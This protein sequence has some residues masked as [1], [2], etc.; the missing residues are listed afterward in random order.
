MKLILGALAVLVL[1][2]FA[3]MYAITMVLA[4]LLPTL[5]IGAVIGMLCRADDKRGR[6][7]ASQPLVTPHRTSLT[8]AHGRWVYL[9]VWVPPATRPPR[10]YIDAEVIEYGR[11]G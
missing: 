6:R 9:S 11:D 7:P 5:I 8:Q 4:Q 1:A 10:P 2:T 3:L